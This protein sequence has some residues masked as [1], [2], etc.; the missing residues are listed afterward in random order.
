MYLLIPYTLLSGNKKKRKEYL[1]V[2]PVKSDINYLGITTRLGKL[3]KNSFPFVLF[4]FFITNPFQ[5]SAQ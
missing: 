5:T 4:C 1:Y 2:I 3:A